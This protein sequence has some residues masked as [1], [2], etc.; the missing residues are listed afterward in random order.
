M[1]RC[2]RRCEACGDLADGEPSAVFARVVWLCVRHS[3]EFHEP[4]VQAVFRTASSTVELW[5]AIK[6]WLF[7][8]AALRLAESRLRLVPVDADWEETMRESA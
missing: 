7:G 4:A 5:A 8:A 2:E 1:R 6:A 3:T